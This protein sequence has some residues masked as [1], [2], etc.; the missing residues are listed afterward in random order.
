ML[1]SVGERLAFG[2]KDLDMLK[3]T[4]L[5]FL[6]VLIILATACI[7]DDDNSNS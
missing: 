4:S 2:E 5:T 3:V 1:L 7:Y 6:G